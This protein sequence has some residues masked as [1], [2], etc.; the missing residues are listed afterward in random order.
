MS[1]RHTLT[2]TAGPDHIDELGHVNNAVWVNWIQDIATAHWA[3]VASPEHQNAYVWVVTRHEIDYRGN[4]VTGESVTAETFI[5]EPPTGARFDR[6]VDF[7]NAQGKVIV[8]AKTT[9]AIIDRASG[10]ILRV[11]KD[12]AAPFLP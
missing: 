12:V 10:R 1:N 9:W 3:A 5:P 6:R 11:P 4:I 7:R 2:F 8:S